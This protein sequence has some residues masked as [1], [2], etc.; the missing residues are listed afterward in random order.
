MNDGFTKKMGPCQNR[1]ANPFCKEQKETSLHRDEQKRILLCVT[2]YALFYALI[3]D[4]ANASVEILEKVVFAII[5]MVI[6]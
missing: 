4:D 6:P 2:F 5:P 1:V 3:N